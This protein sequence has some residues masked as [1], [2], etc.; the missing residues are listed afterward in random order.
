MTYKYIWKKN[1][2]YYLWDNFP[3]WEKALKVARYHKRRNGSRYFIIKAEEGR[4]FPTIRYYLYMDKV[5]KIF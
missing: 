1:R 2:K 3:T 5:M 4:W